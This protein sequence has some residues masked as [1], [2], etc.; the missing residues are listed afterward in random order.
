MSTNFPWPRIYFT[1]RKH[2]PVIS[3]FMTTGVTSGA[4]TANCLSSPPG[5]SGVRVTSSLVLCVCFVDRCLLL[6]FLVIVLSIL[7]QFTDSDYFQTLLG[8]D[9]SIKEK[10]R[11]WNSCIGPN[12]PSQL[13]VSNAVFVS[14]FSKS[15]QI[16]MCSLFCW[17]LLYNP[18][19]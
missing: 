9:T 14:Y 16:S 10:W 1:C 19:H 5:F 12:H 4:G 17:Q 7:H 18:R 15:P 11:G 2:F 8:T 3:S 13:F 6:F